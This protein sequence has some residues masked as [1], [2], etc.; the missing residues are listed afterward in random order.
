MGGGGGGGGVYTTLAVG[1]LV[2]C[3]NEAVGKKCEL[4]KI[5]YFFLA[6][7]YTCKTFAQHVFRT[8][9]INH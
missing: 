8:C 1:I 7:N 2:E 6:Y 3:S 4:Y 9:V 5:D